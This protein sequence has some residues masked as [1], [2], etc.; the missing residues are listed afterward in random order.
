MEK[1]KKIRGLV[2]EIQYPNKSCKKKENMREEIT[3]EII[4]FHFLFR[5]KDSSFSG[6]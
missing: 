1:A 3:Y 5:L 6:K 4:F 2:Q